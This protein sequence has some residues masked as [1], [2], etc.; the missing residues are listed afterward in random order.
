MFWRNL[1][2]SHPGYQL[3]NLD[4]IG[5]NTASQGHIPGPLPESVGEA[6]V[7]AAT[8]TGKIDETGRPNKRHKEK[9]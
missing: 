3:A 7:T 4:G 1:V 5:R 2:E 8:S 6:D 9:E